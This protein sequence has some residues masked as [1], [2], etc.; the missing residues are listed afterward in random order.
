MLATRAVGSHLRHGGKVLILTFNKTLRN[1]VRS[2]VEAVPEDFDTGSII[3]SNYHSF[4]NMNLKHCG[5]PVSPPDGQDKAAVEKHFDSFYSNERMF[6]GVEEMLFQYDSIFLDEIQDYQTEWIKIIRKYFLKE[7]G[8]MVLY[9]DEGQNIYERDLKGPKSVIVQGFGSWER[10]TRSMRS[11]V[12]S[13]LAEMTK[14]FHER[15]LLPKYDVDLMETQPVSGLLSLDAPTVSFYKNESP[16]IHQIVRSILELQSKRIAIEDITVICSNIEILRKCEKELLKDHS[17]R[18]ITTFESEKNFVDLERKYREPEF[19]R[20]IKDIRG[21][22]KFSFDQSSPCLKLSTV[23]SFKGM[24]S[25]TVLFIV[26][27][28]DSEEILYTGMTRAKQYL[29]LQISQQSQFVEFFETQPNVV[30]EDETQLL[31]SGLEKR[32]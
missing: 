3:I 12:A 17:I 14:C 32:V 30:L 23:H 8:E 28:E 29:A 1:F 2:R 4:L 31:K 25:N 26:V 10:L 11:E 9:G 7:G 20:K 24:E 15:Y 27:A 13:P 16:T 18:A 6:L 5:L 21:S 19:S 22:K